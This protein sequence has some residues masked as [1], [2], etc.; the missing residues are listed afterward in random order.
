[1]LLACPQAMFTAACRK[2]NAAKAASL[3]YLS[4]IWTLMADGLVFHKLPS[5]LSLAGAAIITAASLGAILWGLRAGQPGAGQDTSGAAAKPT[6][7]EYKQEHYLGAAAGGKHSARALAAAYSDSTCEG[8]ALPL[9]MTAEA[10][11]QME[12]AE[13]GTEKQGPAV[14]AAALSRIMLKTGADAT[15]MAG[16][17][18]PAK[19]PLTGWLTDSSKSWQL[20]KEVEGE[21]AAAGGVPYAG[22]GGIVLEAVGAPQEALGAPEDA[23]GVEL[24]AVAAAPAATRTSSE[25]E[26]ALQA[27]GK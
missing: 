27:A 5:S 2:C 3:D 10:Q 8:E 18:V 17:A 6:P 14:Q 7:L 16:R 4:L 11:T 21:A 13:A 25:K 26:R 19:L 23:L 15:G 24:Q 20:G 12:A 1:M 9:I 22:S